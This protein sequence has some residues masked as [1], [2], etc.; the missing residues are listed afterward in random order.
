M[1]LLGPESGKTVGRRTR[2]SWSISKGNCRQAHPWIHLFWL[3]PQTHFYWKPFI[4][5][6]RLAIRYKLEPILF[7]SREQ[8]LCKFDDVL[9]KSFV[10]RR[11]S[12]SMNP[13]VM[14]LKNFPFFTPQIFK[15]NFPGWFSPFASISI[16]K[17]YVN[18]DFKRHVF[19]W[20]LVSCP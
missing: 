11:E 2:I 4:T 16:N 15:R 10:K 7:P 14:V 6:G 19:I 5:M 8:I 1:L 12:F 18:Y 20:V 17:F 13:P 3:T 9:R